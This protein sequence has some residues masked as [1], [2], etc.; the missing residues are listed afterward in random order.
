MY[1]GQPIGVLVA[2]AGAAVLYAADKPV[3]GLKELQRFDNPDG[4]AHERD[5]TSDL[6]GRAFDSAGQGRH[7]MEQQVSPK[8]EAA[9]RFAAEL[10]DAVAARANRFDKLYLIAAPAFLGRLRQAL[11]G[12][13]NG[14]PTVEIDKDYTTLDARALRERLPEYL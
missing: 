8:E 10:A 9:V 2:D 7:A 14:L 12:R 5:L 1:R 3:S 11:G 6:P 4:R 13:L